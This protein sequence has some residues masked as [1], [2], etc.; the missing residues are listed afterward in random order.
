[1]EV[2]FSEFFETFKNALFVG[3]LL[4]TAS[5]FA[6]KI[7]NRFSAEHLQIV[8]TCFKFGYF[9]YFSETKYFAKMSIKDVWQ[10]LNSYAIE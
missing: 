10:V 3:Q 6:K 1:M 4:V 7:D 5:E 9:E 8:I 2:F